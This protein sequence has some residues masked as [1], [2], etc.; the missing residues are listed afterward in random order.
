VFGYD[1]KVSEIDPRS[2]NIKNIRFST[3][4][5]SE[6]YQVRIEHDLPLPMIIMGH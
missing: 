2:G 5:I 6:L 1:A 4:N 3:E